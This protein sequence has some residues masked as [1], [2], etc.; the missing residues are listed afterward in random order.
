MSFNR[1]IIKHPHKDLRFI[2]IFIVMYPAI[3]CAR[4]FSNL[5]DHRLKPVQFYSSVTLRSKNERLPVFKKENIIGLGRFLREDLKS[6]IIKDVA[7][8]IDLKERCSLMFMTPH[9]HF[10]KVLR[11]TVH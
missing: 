11:I 9:Q 7:I 5:N 2:K 3:I 6:P 8:L 10:L 4:V 1:G